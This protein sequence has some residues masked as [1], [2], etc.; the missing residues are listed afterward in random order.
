[1]ANTS[2]T[3][4]EIKT[5]IQLLRS[6]IA[7]N[8]WR[9]LEKRAW[10]TIHPHFKDAILG[11][12]AGILE[13]NFDTK[14]TMRKECI[15]GFKNKA[16]KVAESLLTN[17]SAE[18]EQLIDSLEKRTIRTK[19][20]IPRKMNCQSCLQSFEGL[21]EMQRRVARSLPATGRDT[22]SP[23]QTDLDE[24]VLLGTLDSFTHP[25]RLRITKLLLTGAL[26]F[27][28]L[29]KSLDLR[30]GHLTFHL[31]RLM[32]S[33]FVVKQGEKYAIT[34]KGI[35]LGRILGALSNLSRG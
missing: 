28:D 16:E 20:L 26:R 6:D 23:L 11:L 18:T 22:E 34:E 21:L 31:G 3:L 14:C 19:G 15:L 7:T 27:S 4:K 32:K 5:D 30:G 12:S 8:L 24:E 1:M 25:L 2:E 13:S 29:S 9:N 35:R 10:E 33:G 17:P